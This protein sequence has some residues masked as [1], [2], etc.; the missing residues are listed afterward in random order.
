MVYLPKSAISFGTA[1][2]SRFVWSRAV[3]GRHAANQVAAHLDTRRSAFHRRRS[4]ARD[5][6]PADPA[7]PKA[8]PA[9]RLIRLVLPLTQELAERHQAKMRR[10]ARPARGTALRLNK[11]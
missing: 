6:Q 5:S 11:K 1:P 7:V 8:R 3:P 9:T 10:R 4:R 2:F